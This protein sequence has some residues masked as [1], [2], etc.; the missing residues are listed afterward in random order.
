MKVCIFE[1]MKDSDV[2]YLTEK[3]ITNGL[4]VQQECVNKNHIKVL[5]K[6]F[7]VGQGIFILSESCL[8]CSDAA[9]L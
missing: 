4:Q 1:K 6:D 9:G 7:K 5:G 3:E 2:F 8:S